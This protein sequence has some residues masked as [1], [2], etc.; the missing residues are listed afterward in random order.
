MFEGYYKVHYLLKDEKGN[1]VGSWTDTI[2]K[3]NSSYHA[4]QL[5]TAQFGGKVH[6]ATV[7]RIKK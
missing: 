2:V 7:D 4:R 1:S 6:I 5:D 3:A